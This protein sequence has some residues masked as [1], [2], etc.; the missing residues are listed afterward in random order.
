[1]GRIFYISVL[2]LCSIT[3]E[4]GSDNEARAAESLECHIFN[5]IVSKQVNAA[6]QEKF[7]LSSRLFMAKAIQLIGENEVKK[8]MPGTLKK[9]KQ[10]IIAAKSDK[11]TSLADY[12][13]AKLESC[14]KKFQEIQA[15]LDK[16]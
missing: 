4:A 12:I 11:N 15:T 1:M 16:E 10:E 9:I 8:I 14:A 13:D 5:S 3:G 6:Q 2:L 7:V